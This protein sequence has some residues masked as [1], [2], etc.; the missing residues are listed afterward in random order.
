MH[1]SSFHSAH[2]CT[3][4]YVTLMCTR[5]KPCAFCFI[6]V[7]IAK[8]TG[9]WCCGSTPKDE[10]PDPRGSLAKTIYLPVL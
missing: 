7:L 8:C 4:M 10:L 6:I 2:S 5:L 9:Q 3:P 1:T